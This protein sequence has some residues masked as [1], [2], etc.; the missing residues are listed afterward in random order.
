MYFRDGDLITIH[1]QALAS[2]ESARQLVA[3][4]IANGVLADDGTGYD[5]HYGDQTPAQ[6]RKAAI[7][8]A[9]SILT[10]GKLGM[11]LAQAFIGSYDL[12]WSVVGADAYGDPVVEFHLTNAMTMNSAMPDPGKV[13][14]YGTGSAG[15]GED[16]GAGER[17]MQM[18]V[19]WRESFPGGKS[20]KPHQD[21]MSSWPVPSGGKVFSVFDVWRTVTFTF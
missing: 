7:D 3:I 19:R 21:L 1:I 5:F 2:I 9:K 17:W 6:R 11:P 16:A 20:Q 8:N 15:N 10:N 12:E 4:A 13:H 18:N 14:N